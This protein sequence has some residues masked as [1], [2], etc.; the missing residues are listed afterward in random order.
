MSWKEFLEPF[1]P[2][3]HSPA[4][5]GLGG[6]STEY[7]M[8]EKSPDGM[9]WN[10]PSIWWGPNGNAYLFKG[11]PDDAW[12]MAKNWEENTGEKFPR[13]E[14]LDAAMMAAARRSDEGGAMK[15]RLTQSG[16]MSNEKDIESGTATE[17]AE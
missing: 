2:A 17:A 1:D 11:R 14:S 6:K 10:I 3:K 4:D 13:F 5:V 12:E 7:L 16:R 9:F 8:S 15:S